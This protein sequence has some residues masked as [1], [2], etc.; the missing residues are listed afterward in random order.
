M[1]TYCP[2]RKTAARSYT[3]HQGRHFAVQR[4]N[5]L[6]I[7]NQQDRRG[8]SLLRQQPLRNTEKMKSAT[9]GDLHVF[10]GERVPVFSFV[11]PATEMLPIEKIKAAT[12]VG[13]RMILGERMAMFSFVLVA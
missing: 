10:L 3:A 5:P 7:S 12:G 11:W 2:I 4:R 9:G 6:S 8:A 13:L 1:L